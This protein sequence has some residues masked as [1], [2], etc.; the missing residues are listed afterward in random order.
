MGHQWVSVEGAAHLASVG[1][2]LARI[3]SP[4]PRLLSQWQLTQVAGPRTETNERLPCVILPSSLEKEVMCKKASG[5]FTST[6]VPGLRPPDRS[7]MDYNGKTL[8]A[9]VWISTSA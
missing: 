5:H 8:R 1:I 4:A 3:D 9:V 7:N 6:M 2:Q